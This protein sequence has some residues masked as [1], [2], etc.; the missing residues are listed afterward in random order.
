MDDE[1]LLI[2]FRR[3]RSVDIQE[4]E[5][6]P[7]NAFEIRMDFPEKTWKE[8]R[9]ECYGYTSEETWK[10]IRAEYY[11]YISGEFTGPAAEEEFIALA[12]EEDSY[13]DVDEWYDARNRAF[14]N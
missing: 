1:P 14:Q 7:F 9:E 5:F 2:I 4:K 12:A 8:I 3:G 13:G 10:E 11:G 6:S